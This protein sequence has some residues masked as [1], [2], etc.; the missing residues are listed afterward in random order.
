[1][2]ETGAG[3]VVETTLKAF[4]GPEEVTDSIKGGSYL[5]YQIQVTN[6][7]TEEAT[8]ISLVGQVPEGTV[9]VEDVVIEEGSETSGEDSIIDGETENSETGLIEHPDIKQYLCILKH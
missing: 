8:N 7:G 9:Y 1:M 6:T 4:N 3:P 2:L 5:T